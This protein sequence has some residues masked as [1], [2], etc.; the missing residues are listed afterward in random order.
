MQTRTQRRDGFTL[1]EL[2]VVIAVIAIL[3]SLLLPALSQA[4][5]KA[6]SVKCKS[7]IHQIGLGL[8]MYVDDNGFFPK[9]KDSAFLRWALAINVYLRQPVAD[10]SITG[11]YRESPQGCFRCPVDKRKVN[12]NGGSYG[13]NAYGISKH[14]MLQ[15]TPA[16]LKLPGLG[17]GGRG[18]TSEKRGTFEFE[19]PVPESAVQVPSEMIALGDAYACSRG[20]FHKVYDVY[21][22]AG[23]LAREGGA[24]S[25]LYLPT[26]RKRHQGRLNL[27]FCDG[28]VEAIKV[29]ALFFSKEVRDMR[30]WNIDNEPHRERMQY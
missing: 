25:P 29:R 17:L 21:E 4:K 23:E 28:H 12:G 7:N 30:L 3:A 18:F 8:Q 9:V 6:Y 11:W 16:S 26:A 27:G 15:G 19:A 5:A 20:L 10:E 22:T 1:V 2:L 24:D 13:Y 14:N